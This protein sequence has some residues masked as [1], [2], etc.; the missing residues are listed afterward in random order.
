MAAVYGEYD[1]RG[2][3]SQDGATAVPPSKGFYD[4]IVMKQKGRW[5]ISVWHESGIPTPPPATSSAR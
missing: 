4:W 3:M 5:L 1:Q 2:L